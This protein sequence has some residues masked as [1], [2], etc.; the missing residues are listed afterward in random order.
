MTLAAI[1]VTA[2]V[3]VVAVSWPEQSDPVKISR[4]VPLDSPAQVGKQI[5]S[6][7][8]V[9]TASPPSPTSLSFQIWR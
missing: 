3:A 6:R 1:C 8:Q 9:P 4:T 2:L 5:G 7:W